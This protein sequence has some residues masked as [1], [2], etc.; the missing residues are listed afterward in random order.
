MIQ[1]LGKAYIHYLIGLLS[2]LAFQE[3]QHPYD[4]MIRQYLLHNIIAL[5]AR[6]RRHEVLLP[7]GL[8]PKVLHNDVAAHAETDRNEPAGR[9]ASKHC[10]DHGGVLL[11]ATW[12][13]QPQKTLQRNADQPRQL[14]LFNKKA[15]LLQP[16]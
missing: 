5:A 15:T 10:I 13:Q 3:R 9:V 14:Q 2:P 8:L 6:D 7:V 4:L 11:S 1:L 12:R 16:S